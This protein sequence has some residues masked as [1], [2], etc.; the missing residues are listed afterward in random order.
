MPMAICVNACQVYHANTS[1]KLLRETENSRDR[2][3]EVGQTRGRELIESLQQC[4][5]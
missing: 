1:N 3:V 2:D 4:K 5:S